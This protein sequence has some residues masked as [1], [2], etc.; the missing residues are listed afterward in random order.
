[1][2]FSLFLLAR[3]LFLLARSQAMGCAKSVFLMPEQPPQSYFGPP[4]GVGIPRD[5]RCPSQP[6]AAEIGPVVG[7]PYDYKYTLRLWPV[8]ARGHRF[9]ELDGFMHGKPE[10]S[11]CGWVE[12]ASGR[13]LGPLAPQSETSGQS[14]PRVYGYFRCWWPSGNPWWGALR[15]DGKLD[16]LNKYGTYV[17]KNASLSIILGLFSQ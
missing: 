8:D 4:E 2:F 6:P 16:C 10:R 5:I 11:V 9:A 14:D 12:P 13:S 7:G 1:M 17:S 3:S 15:L